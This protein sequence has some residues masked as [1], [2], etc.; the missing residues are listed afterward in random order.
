MK[1]KNYAVALADLILLGM[2]ILFMACFFDVRYLFYDTI[3]TGGDTASWYGVAD[4]MLNVLLPNGRL[5]GWDMG[6]FCGYPNFNFYFIPPFLMAVLPSYLFNIPLTITLKL[7]IMTG[8]FA[9]PVMTYFGLRAMRYTF[10]T[11][12]VGASVSLLFLF[13]ESYTMFGGNTLSTFAGEFCYMFAF[14]IFP[15]FMGSLYR[16]MNGG[17]RVILNGILLGLIGLSHLFVFMPAVFLLIYWYLRKGDIRYLLKISLIAA[18]IMAFWI[19]PLMAYR[20]PYTTPVYFIWNQFA[21]WRYSFAG[22]GIIILFICPGLTLY[23]IGRYADSGPFGKMW[24]FSILSISGT[25][26]FILTYL[27]ETYMIFGRK[28]WN[29]GL[30][31]PIFS[32]SILGADT[33]YIFHPFVVHIALAV[34][35]V[36]TGAGLWSLRK[37]TRYE[38]FC[39]ITGSVSLLI[40]LTLVFMKFYIIISSSITEWEIRTFLMKSST[41]VVV[42]GVLAMTATWF[43]LFSKRLKTFVLLTAD[44]KPDRFMMFL[45]LAFGCIVGYFSAHFM[46]IPDIRFF[47]PLIFALILIF[48]ADT[49]GPFLGSLSLKKKI[50][51]AITITYICI[52][53]V[54]LGTSKADDWFRYNNEGYEYRAGYHDFISVNNYL[55]TCYHGKFIDALNAPRVGYEKCDLYGQ[56]GGARVFESIPLFSGRQTLEGIHYA[57]SIAAKFNAFL[58]TEFSRDIKTPTS[59]IFSKIN[60]KSLPQHFDLYNLSQLILMTDEAR[61]AAAASPFFEKEAEFGAIS[62]Y[63]YKACNGRYV[64]APKVYPVLYLRDDWV[65]AFFQWYKRPELADVLF[66][67]GKFVKNKED[68][69]TFAGETSDIDNLADFKKNVIDQNDLKINTYLEHLRIRFTTNGI[70]LPHLIKVSYFPNWKVEGANAVYPVSPHLMLVIPRENEV[71]LTY[72]TSLWEKAGMALTAGTL[73]ILL[74][75]GIFRMMPRRI[76]RSFTEWISC[77][78]KYIIKPVERVLTF[79]RPYMLVIVIFC[80]CA[81]VTG[82]TLLRN[83]QVRLYIQGHRA[84]KTAQNLCSAGKPETARK[85]FKDAIRIMEPITKNRFRYDHADVIHCILFTAMSYENLGERDKAETMYRTILTD[86]PYSRYTGEA[87]VKIGRIKKRG[88]NSALEDGL[89]KLLQKDTAEGLQSVRKALQQTGEVLRYFNQAISNDPYSVWARYARRD[90]EKERNYIRGKGPA[91][92]SRCHDEDIRKSVDAILRD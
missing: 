21:N 91:I 47:P 82:G 10:P 84:F 40:G 67:P 74:L 25:G 86:F 72:K 31:I 90:L 63:R 5:S 8:I 17:G 92:L 62:V 28:M 60:P 9:L 56:Y 79:A 81:L 54:Y 70:G 4:H 42:H 61:N 53:A 78:L 89:K 57:S 80:S 35:A 71:T 77:A 49:L 75:I 18:G 69:A 12:I 15:Y 68:R 32:E 14:A 48:F 58:Q 29:T 59:Y 33:A 26:V 38:N 36:V 2:I 83:K 44:D 7:A 85:H 13:N 1:L 34:T 23:A 66:V 11:P 39:W 24:K 50:I 41:M 46:E 27:A 22:L 37:Q 76:R 65:N 51:G 19:L 88:R 45:S 20:H 6:N 52:V 16:G 64:D 87:Y 30:S 73:I 3:V 55:K 43:F